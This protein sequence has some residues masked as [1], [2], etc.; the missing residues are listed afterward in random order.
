MPPR[1]LRG[2]AL[3]AESQQ[4]GVVEAA[5]DACLELAGLHVRAGLTGFLL[6]R[7]RMLFGYLEGPTSA[8]TAVTTAIDESGE[9]SLMRRIPLGELEARVCEGWEV[10]PV[11]RAHRGMV[12]LDAVLEQT[13]RMR[14]MEPLEAKQ[15]EQIVRLAQ[16]LVR[17]WDLADDEGADCP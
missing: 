16:Q 14:L 6:V 7:Q 1:D 3:L 15:R 13:I 11:E 17:F 4:P 9:L 12:G 5:R 10:R 8:M 2:L